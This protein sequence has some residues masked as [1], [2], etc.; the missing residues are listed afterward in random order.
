MKRG[1]ERTLRSA[2]PPVSAPGLGRPKRRPRP[3]QPGSNC[4]P[5]EHMT[6]WGPQLLWKKASHPNPI[7]EDPLLS[8]PFILVLDPTVSPHFPFIFTD[9]PFPSPVF[10]RPVSLSSLLSA[11]LLPPAPIRALVPP[12]VNRH[13]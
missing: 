13:P 7:T 11:I 2:L 3:K 6:L 9:S 10:Q 4:S 5:V 1:V 8:I 12:S